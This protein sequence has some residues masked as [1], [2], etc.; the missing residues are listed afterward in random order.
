MCSY[1]KVSG[2]LTIKNEK[3]Y[4]EDGTYLKTINCP[5]NVS[6]QDLHQIS[7]TKFS[8]EKCAKEVVQTDFLTEKQII[9][10]LTTNPD[11]CLKISLFDPLFRVEK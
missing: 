11:T 2:M 5:L 1:L 7:E 9:D 3:I 4:A 8:C 6:D 10:L